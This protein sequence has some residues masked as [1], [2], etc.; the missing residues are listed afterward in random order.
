M[1]TTRL[2]LAVTGGSARAAA[3]ALSSA[4]VR[5][6]IP[7][8]SSGASTA[9]AGCN[10][11]P[12]AIILVATQSP[13]AKDHRATSGN[14]QLRIPVTARLFHRFYR[15]STS[16]ERQHDQDENQDEE[17]RERDLD[18]ALRILTADPPRN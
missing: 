4:A 8:V 17:H 7:R 6:S 1:K 10:G 18:P 15:R 5:A 13:S 2:P 16:A 14:G 3:Q 9:C 11:M 12:T